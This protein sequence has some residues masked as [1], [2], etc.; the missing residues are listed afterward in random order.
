M[1]AVRS[2]AGSW[3]GRGGRWRGLLVLEAGEQRKRQRLENEISIAREVQDQLFPRGLPKVEG[4]EIE[5]IWGEPVRR[6][7]RASVQ[8]PRTEMIYEFLKQL[9][10][11]RRSQ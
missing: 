10:R 2:R 8:M 4:L 7:Q 1:P 9:D 11:A 6:A 5:A 3:D